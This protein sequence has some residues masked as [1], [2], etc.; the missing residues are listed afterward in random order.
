MP[1]QHDEWEKSL[2]SP[3]EGGLTIEAY[4]RHFATPIGSKIL[5]D[6]LIDLCVF[7]TL[8]TV[9]D[10]AKHNAG[11]KLLISTGVLRPNSEGRLNGTDIQKLVSKLLAEPGKRRTG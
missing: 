8:R 11:I 10:M 4:R 3:N 2:R 7:S 1:K 5:A 6:M 9:E